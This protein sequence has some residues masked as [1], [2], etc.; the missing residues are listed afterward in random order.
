MVYLKNFVTAKS[1]V[2]ARDG[3]ISAE[4]RAALDMLGSSAP[5]RRESEIIPD[6]TLIPDNF[7]TSTTPA[8]ILVGDRYIAR[9]SRNGLMLIDR[10][11]A[12]IRI[13]YDRF[14]SMLGERRMSS[15]HLMFPETLTLS[16]AEDVIMASIVDTLAEAGI[17][18]RTASSSL[19][20]PAAG[21]RP[22]SNWS[23]SWVE[24]R[25][26]STARRSISATWTECTGG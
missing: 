20:P 24:G 21:S 12:H 14:T 16:P 26:S 13:L 2:Y 6:D 9:R 10:R 19:K 15:Q 22:P 25:S 23:S 3:E 8:Y 1:H 17:E 7:A 18:G 11:R 4:T 5:A